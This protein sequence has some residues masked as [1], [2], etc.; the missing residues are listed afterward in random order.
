MNTLINL[1]LIAIIISII[2][3]NS[4]FPDSAKKALS[5]ILSKGKIVKTDYRFHL[6]DCEFCQ[7]W[8]IGLIYLLCVGKF[9]IPYITIVC[10]LAFCTDRIGEGLVL[11]KDLILKVFRLIREFSKI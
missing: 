11:F 8:W 5:W 6:I 7:M 4:D 2:T 10:L 1:F 9:T 3:G